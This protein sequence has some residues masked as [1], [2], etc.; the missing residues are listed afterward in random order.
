[1]IA[2]V[3]V[4]GSSAGTAYRRVAAVGPAVAAQHGREPSSPRPGQ[5]AQARP[6]DLRL[7]AAT[8]AAAVLGALIHRMGGAAASLAR[9]AYV[10]VAV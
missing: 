7:Q 8:P 6:A 5:P 9:G 4:V 10:D 3:R 2:S 1:M